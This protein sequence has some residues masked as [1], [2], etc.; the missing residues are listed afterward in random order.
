[1]LDQ[2]MG[3]TKCSSRGSTATFSFLLLAFFVVVIIV[4]NKVQ[5]S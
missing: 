3:D 2:L 4:Q 5:L 1:M